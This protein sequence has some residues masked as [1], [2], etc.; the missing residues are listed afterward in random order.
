MALQERHKLLLTATPLQN[1]LLELFGLVS[2]IDEHTFGNLRS[3]RDQFTNLNAQT[4]E[5]LKSRL[6]PIC[7]RT[8]RRHVTA[9][10]P[11]TKRHAIVQPFDPGES[12][13]ALYHLVSDYLQRDNL[14]ALQPSQRRLMT[15]VLR[16]L[17]ASSFAIAGALTSM[18]NRMKARLKE[19]EE[20]SAA[21][22]L[23]PLAKELNEDYEALD[24][25]AEEWDEE[26]EAEP[27]T[28]EDRKAMQAEIVDLEEFTRLAVSIDHNAKGR[29]LLMALKTAFQKASE[30]GAAEKA[31]IFTESRK[32]QSYLLRLLA[33]SPYADG[34]VLF[35]GTNTDDRSKAIYAKWAARH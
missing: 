10:V 15:L 8:L 22:L 29:A 27:L 5:A 26:Q 25:T 11:Y 23:S 24:E 20:R 12:A 1:S 35:N 2:V 7:H 32:T 17:L 9:Y 16:K 31:I 6:K 34:I 13:D 33:D 14:Q 19:D 30:L 18:A 28:I 4:F 21:T 3:F